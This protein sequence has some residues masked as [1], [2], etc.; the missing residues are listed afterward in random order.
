MVASTLYGSERQY[1]GQLYEGASMQTDE[2]LYKRIFGDTR[3]LFFVECGALNGLS[4][5]NCRFFEE[6]LG[7]TGVNVEPTSAF[8]DLV[9]NRPRCLNLKLA[10]SDV[11]HAEICLHENLE[12]LACSSSERE[13][14]APSSFLDGKEME[15]VL[16]PRRVATLTFASLMR[17]LRIDRVDLFSLDVEGMELAVLRGM[18]GSPVM[19]RFLFVETLH[20]DRRE[21]DRQLDVLGYFKIEDFHI[22]ALYG[23]RVCP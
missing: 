3:D 7:W 13:I 23:L 15:S 14:A 5:S 16:R 1:Y 11:D 4:L 22:D 21:L 20:T 12:N 10:L 19:P 6:N 18:Q 8:D 2:W 17:W 9:I